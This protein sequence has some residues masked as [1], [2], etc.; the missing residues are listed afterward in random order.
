MA[1][2]SVD[3]GAERAFQRQG[4]PVLHRAQGGCRRRHHRPPGRGRTGGAGGTNRLSPIAEDGDR[5]AVFNVQET[6]VAKTPPSPAVTIT[7]L[8]D[9]QVKALGKVREISPAVDPASGVGPGQGRH[10]RHAGRHAAAAQP[11][12]VG[13]RPD[14]RKPSSCRLAGADVERGQAGCLDRR[15]VDQGGGNG[16]GQCAGLRFRRRRSSTRGW[17]P[18]KA[19]SPPAASCS[20]PDRRSRISGAGQ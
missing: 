19:S 11:S 1:Q 14:R 8:S 18:D 6:L 20:A 3:A 12:S 10:S 15:S 17:R 5:D 2:G 7:L 4:E 13:Q 9:P 16:T